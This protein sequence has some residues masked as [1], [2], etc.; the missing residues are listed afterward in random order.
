MFCVHMCSW[1]TGR[2]S[3]GKTPIHGINTASRLQE[4]YWKQ[5]KF[6]GGE[7]DRIS[8]RHFV[9][10]SEAFPGVRCGDGV[11]LDVLQIHMPTEK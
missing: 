1:R 3:L 5:A 6:H 2:T 4:D 8:D 10:L 7:G 11:V 9:R